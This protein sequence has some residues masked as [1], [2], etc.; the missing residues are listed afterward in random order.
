MII[1]DSYK[2]GFYCLNVYDDERYTRAD[3]DYENEEDD[4]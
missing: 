3:E 4:N 2:P 1:I